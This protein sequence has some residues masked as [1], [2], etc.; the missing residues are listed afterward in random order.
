[1]S[2][3]LKKLDELISWARTKFKLGKSRSLSLWKGER[4]DRAIFTISGENIPIIADQ[5]IQS[6]GRQY[7][8]SLSHKEMGKAMLQQR[9]CTRLMPASCPEKHKV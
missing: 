9:A 4:N 2:R 6:L 1:M 8:S 7:T 3:L 5:P